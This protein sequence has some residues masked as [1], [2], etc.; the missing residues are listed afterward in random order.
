MNSKSESDFWMSG[1]EDLAKGYVEKKEVFMCLICDEVYEKGR[2]YEEDGKLYDSEK[3]VQRHITQNHGSV[4]NYY[5]A[6]NTAYSGISEVQ[7]DVIELMVQGMTDREIAKKLG[8]AD[9]TI[10]NHRFK[11]REKE[12]QA[13]IFLTIMKLLSEHDKEEEVFEIHKTATSIDERYNITDKE[14]KDTRKAY[15]DENGAL[16]NFPAREKRK[17]I[18]L[19]E[20]MKNFAKGKKYTE[21]E[22]NRVLSRIQDDYPTL[23]RY[24]IEYGFLDR[25]NDGK[26]YWVKE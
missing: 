26:F 17:I 20:I 10:R 5:L 13:K 8:V 22:I 23:R 4:L 19:Q 11:L 7:R 18:V 14:I 12:K 1:P 16:K 25:T 2:I 9:S 6:M 3:T 21:P 15:F 24:L